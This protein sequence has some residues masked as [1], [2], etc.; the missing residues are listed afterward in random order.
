[1]ADTWEILDL[2][3]SGQVQLSLITESGGR[4]SAPP[5]A[6]PFPLTDAEIHEIRWLLDGY[7]RNPFGA[8]RGRAE[9]AAAGLRDLGRL[10]LETL[11]RSGDARGA[12]AGAADGGGFRPVPGVSGVGTAGVPGAAVGNAERP[13]SGLSGAAGRGDYAAVRAGIATAGIFRGGVL[14]D[15]QFNVLLIGPPG[16]AGL[17]AEALS[18]M[19][20]LAVEVSLECLRPT[21]IDAL[22]AASGGGGPGII[23]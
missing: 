15:T 13:G 21:S 11:F 10:M 1:M 3:A 4:E 9:R 6:F 12:M 17:A 18:A 20:S 19:E 22:E 8:A 5:A 23:I 7:A 14:P 2:A 16:A